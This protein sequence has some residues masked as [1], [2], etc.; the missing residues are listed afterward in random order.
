VIAQQH[1]VAAERSSGDAARA[2]VSKKTGTPLA[3]TC[4]PRA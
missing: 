2:F 3:R 4:A 1:Q